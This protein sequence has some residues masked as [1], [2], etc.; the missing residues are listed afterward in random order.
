[1]EEEER[2]DEEKENGTKR[3]KGESIVRERG[4][5]NCVACWK[6]KKIRCECVFTKV[7]F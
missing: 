2:G 7:P 6:C 4:E 3:G 1:M 5:R